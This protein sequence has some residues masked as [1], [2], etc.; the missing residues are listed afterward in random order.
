VEKVVGSGQDVHHKRLSALP[1]TASSDSYHK[2]LK[3]QFKGVVGTPKWA[4]LK[5]G[6]AEEED[7]S[8]K[9]LRV[10]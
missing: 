5:E 8:T 9:V 7:F 10:G 3:E 2:M 4:A 1:E 6:P